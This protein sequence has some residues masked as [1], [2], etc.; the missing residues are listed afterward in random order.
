MIDILDILSPHRPFV[1]IVTP[2]VI[3]EPTIVD[4]AVFASRITDTVQFASRIVDTLA[5]R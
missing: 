4:T 3:L 2:P 1:F 5:F